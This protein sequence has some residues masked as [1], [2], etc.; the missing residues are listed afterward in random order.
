MT[1]LGDLW[2]DRP[3]EHHRT[4]ANVAG[5]LVYA[6]GDIHGCYELVCKLLGYIRV[7]CELRAQGRRPILIFLGDYIDRGP[8]SKDV[9]EA[10]VWLQRHSDWEVHMLKGNHEQCLLSFLDNPADGARWLE[11]GGAQTLESYGV[12]VPSTRNRQDLTRTSTELLDSMPASHYSLLT[13]LETF[14]C[15]GDYAFVHAGV[16]PGADFDKQNP[17]D[18]LWIRRDFVSAND[19]FERIVVH[20][21]TWSTDQPEILWNRI[22]VD[23]G[24]YVTGVLTGLCLEDGEIRVLQAR[25]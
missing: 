7:D 24:A 6:V 10:M 16:R 11:F 9:V 1:D 22:G 5:Q 21:H 18:L 4:E 3:A 15:I 25:N 17:N 12:G 13:N 19:K 8:R 20:G 14:L 23:T 2:V